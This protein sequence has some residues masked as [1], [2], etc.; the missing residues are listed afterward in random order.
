MLRVSSTCLISFIVLLTACDAPAPTATP[1]ATA[2]AAVQ[3]TAGGVATEKPTASPNR[4]GEPITATTETTLAS[5]TS[6]PAKY[7]NTEV[8]TSGVVKAVC[9]K[10]GCWM[11]IGDETSQAHIKMAGHK[12]LVPRTSDGRKA[13]VQGTVKEGAPQNECGSK[14]QCGGEE[15]GAVAKVEIIATGVEFVD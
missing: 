5:I 10:A 3:S 7:A 15:N 13:V 6:D 14:D 12:F 2:T 11:E 9:K 1:D 8:K 4:F